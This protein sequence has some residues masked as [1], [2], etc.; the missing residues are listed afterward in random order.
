MKTPEISFV[1]HSFNEEK[2]LPATLKR[3]RQI[4]EK[5]KH[6]VEII[7][8]DE[9]ST[10]NSLKIARSFADKTFAISGN[11]IFG[12]SRD[13]ACSKANGEI[14]V[15]IDPDILLPYD[16]V[17][18]IIKEFK[19]PNVVAMTCDVFVYPDEEIFKD[20]IFQ[21]FRNQWY[22]FLNATRILPIG[23]ELHA[24]RKSAYFVIGGY[25]SKLAMCED[26]DIFLRL[27]KIGKVVYSKKLKVYESPARYRKYGYM[28]TYLYWTIGT[29]KYFLNIPLTEYKRVSH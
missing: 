17:D 27:S 2:R 12:R 13:F 24:V 14:I 18:E 4:K 10:D 15:S 9:G 5:T 21:S 23:H 29:L 19:D 11:P 3:L 22:W 6:N 16:A 8:V 26:T 25:N 20:K 1:V 7:A 28:K